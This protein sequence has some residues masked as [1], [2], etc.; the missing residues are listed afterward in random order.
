MAEH[1]PRTAPFYTIPNRRIV[2][3]EHPAIIQNVDKAIE[4][5]Q[6]NQGIYQIL[7]PPKSDTPANLRLRPEDPFARPVQSIS[8]P[9]NNVLLKVT[10]PKRTGRRRKRGSNEP[11]TPSPVGAT[12][13]RPCAKELLRTLRDNVGQYQ[14]EAVGSVTRT[15]VFRAMPDFAFS[16][17]SSPF[18][19]RFR[20][21]ILSF[22]LDKMKQFDL[23]MSKGTTTNADIIPPPFF[24]D[25][26]I[27]F[28]YMYRQNPIVKQSIDTT[29][30]V[31]TI[32]TQQAVRIRTYLVPY[33]I[34]QVPTHPRE[35][36]P[37]LA[38]QEQTVKDTVAAIEALFTQRPAWT[39][40]AL[41]NALPTL[42]QRY[43]LRM[44][45][46]YVGYIFRSGPWRDAIVK[47]GH[48]PRVDPAY[49]IFQTVMFRGNRVDF[50][51]VGRRARRNQRPAA[52]PDA[53][54]D[55]EPAVLDP[56]ATLTTDSHI[57]TG[58]P[59]LPRDGRMW[60]F[61]DIADPLLRSIVRLDAAA[62][63]PGFLRETCDTV[64][65][66]WFGSGTLAKLK[67]IMRHKILANE[68]GR[69]P[70]DADFV[71]L[72]DLPDHADPENFLA[73][74]SL[75]PAVAT[76]QELMLATEV[77]SVIKGT[78]SWREKNAAAAG[79]K[80]AKGKAERRVQWE[81]EGGDEGEGEGEESE[82]EEE[83]LEQEEILEAAVDAMDAAEESTAE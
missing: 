65:D 39:R 75:D 66:G 81:D 4:T 20:E 14:V 63:P 45:I 51:S 57:F 56:S 82:G 23:D 21:Q 79:E 46:P 73:E 38:E 52:S 62:P 30:K 35:N 53:A 27:P 72:L 2:S 19:Q 50:D 47:F 13:Q 61:C 11:F 48:D 1:A 31:T 17:S 25:G 26:D 28:S 9:S 22:D 5:L 80:T 6:G 64:S 70:D 49:R 40:R 77:R 54:D 60:M 37:P 42:E 8:T 83:E 58:Q 7:N 16:L 41:R 36:C 34:S 69:V 15:H 3:V 24:S 55:R 29:G 67:T 74:F 43:A 10:V 18:A 33:D 32:N 44:A 12:S 78:A 76:S 59:P 71:R 68:E